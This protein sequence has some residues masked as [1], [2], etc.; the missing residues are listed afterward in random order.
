[1][2]FTAPLG[3]DGWRDRVSE[4][5]E[6]ARAGTGGGFGAVINRLILGCIQQAAQLQNMPFDEITRIVAPND[7][8][9]DKG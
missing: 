4:R 1:M 3:D 5:V 6:T 7:K 8:Q 9:R 2:A